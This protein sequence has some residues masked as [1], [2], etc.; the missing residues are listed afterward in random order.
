VV[1][2]EDAVATTTTTRKLKNQKEVIRRVERQSGTKRRSL[3]LLLR[4]AKNLS[5]SSR[6]AYLEPNVARRVTRQAKR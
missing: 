2:T 4:M 6:Q 5:D 1:P 3:A